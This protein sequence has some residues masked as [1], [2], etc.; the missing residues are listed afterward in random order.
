MDSN[1]R[2]KNVQLP[3]PG[4]EPSGDLMISG[5]GTISS[6]GPS[7]FN[8]RVVSAPYVNDASKLSMANVGNP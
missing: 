3:D 5:W 6:G 2:V 7:P 1:F 4:A 8:L